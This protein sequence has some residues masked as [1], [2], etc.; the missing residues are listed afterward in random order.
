MF[1]NVDK[2]RAGDYAGRGKSSGKLSRITNPVF[3]DRGENGRIQ[4]ATTAFVDPPEK[5]KADVLL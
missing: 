1:L 3:A 4:I 2:A 5:R